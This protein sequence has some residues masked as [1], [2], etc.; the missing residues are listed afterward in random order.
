MRYLFFGFFPHGGTKAEAREVAKTF[1]AEY[2]TWSKV[3]TPY[4][5]INKAFLVLREDS[6]SQHSVL[7]FLMY[8]LGYEE[9]SVET[10]DCPGMT[11]IIE[12][13][14]RDMVHILREGGGG[15]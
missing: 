10:L 1:G 15:E 12:M 11:I 9:L 14:T 4:G 5:E 7:L 6:C 2:L 8:E 13:C 3:R